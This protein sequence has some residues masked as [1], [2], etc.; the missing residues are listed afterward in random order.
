[1]PYWSLVVLLLCSGLLCAAEKV[2]VKI[3]DRRDSEREYS[4]TAPQ[5]VHATSK[6]DV[7]CRAYPNSANCDAPT[8]AT[9]TVTPP[10]TISYSVRGATFSLLLP[11][12][13]VVVVNCDSKY[14]LRGDSINRRSCRTPI[15]DEIDVE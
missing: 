7:N 6:T 5:E 15:A 13:K 4:Y 10:Q 14:K 12:G 2:K 11:N 9:G 8:K 1:M 3:I